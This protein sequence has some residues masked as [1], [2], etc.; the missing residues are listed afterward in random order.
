MK[1]SKLIVAGALLAAVVALKLL[2][3]ELA[4]DVRSKMLDVL[5]FDRDYRAVFETL[6]D[7]LSLTREAAEPHAAYETAAPAEKARAEL[8]SYHAEE[9]VT[10]GETAPSAEAEA[11]TE[12]PEAVTVFLESQAAFSDYGLPEN[13]D[14]GY[15]ALP[16]DF[17]VPV[18][19]YNSSGFGYRLHPI[20]NTVRF[21]YGTDFAANSGDDVLA[22]ADGVVT[23]AARSDSY[24]NYITID[25]GDGW[26]SLYAHCSRL[27]VQSGQRV[28]AGER[29]ALVG[30]T[31][32][33]TGPHLHFEL[34]HDGIYLNPEYYVND[35]AG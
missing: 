19:G 10:L 29:I 32:L 26:T 24:G 33:A 31:G 21:H 27:Y 8:V 25:H 5:V 14:Y 12:L 22:F 3:P 23:L 18:S 15:Q 17:A 11:R 2:L 7:R 28:S 1:H 13:V 35:V 30:S 4:A 6:G 16:F 34:Q 9:A 20:L